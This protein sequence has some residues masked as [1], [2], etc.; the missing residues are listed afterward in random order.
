MLVTV[1]VPTKLWAAPCLHWF[2][3]YSMN[4]K[5]C[6]GKV[7]T[8]GEMHNSDHFVLEVHEVVQHTGSG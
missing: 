3:R 7:Q 8:M 2:V 4:V 5:N 1:E 6:Q